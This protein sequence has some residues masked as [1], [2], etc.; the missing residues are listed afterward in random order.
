[1]KEAASKS[2]K[3]AG[4]DGAH[5][6]KCKWYLADD[7]RQEIGGKL[8]LVGLYPDDV[9]L[10][11]MPSDEPDP[12]PDQP[13]QLAGLA[14]L[15]VISGL[16]GSAPVVFSFGGHRSPEV[17][18]TGDLKSSRNLISRFPVLRIVSLGMKSASI[19]I[20][21]I[22]FHDEFQFE[23]RRRS[24]EP[25]SEAASDT[26]IVPKGARRKR[27]VSQADQKKSRARRSSG[28]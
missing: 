23:V 11:E 9:V 12:T 19:D 2:R 21:S 25:L 15:C 10:I 3:T 17:D 5:G 27:S 4:K 8:T 6:V 1:M 13:I 28:A 26:E 16:E 20:A 22:G 24:T 7:I 18:V 14:I